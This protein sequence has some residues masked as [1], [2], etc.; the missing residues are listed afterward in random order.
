MADGV[1]AHFSMIFMV[2]L[3]SQEDAFSLKKP[4]SVSPVAL[5]GHAKHFCQ[6]QYFF[7]CGSIYGRIN[8]CSF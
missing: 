6:L 3:R 7:G 4:R 8:R 2:L 1:F 5:S